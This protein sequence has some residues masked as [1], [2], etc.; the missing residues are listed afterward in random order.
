[1]FLPPCLP[2][3]EPATCHIFCLLSTP[4][5]K[6]RLISPFFFFFFI[7]SSRFLVI[8]FVFVLPS[9]SM[10]LLFSSSRFLISFLSFRA[11][12]LFPLLSVS[13]FLASF[14]IS[15]IFS[16]ASPLLGFLL[17]SFNLSFSVWS[18]NLPPSY[19]LISTIVSTFRL[20]SSPS[21]SFLPTP[22][23]H[24]FAPSLRPNLLRCQYS[25]RQLGA[26]CRVTSY[27][28]SE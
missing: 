2:P 18:R 25:N 4:S 8:V 14:L 13:S 15:F 24:H 19:L 3:L 21:F 7:S 20:V 28:K 1:M 27:H 5:L 22:S 10:V 16:Y 9:F 11:L 26:S 12:L 6:H 17:S 23:F